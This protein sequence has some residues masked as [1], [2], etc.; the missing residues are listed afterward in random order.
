M[1]RRYGGRLAAD[2]QPPVVTPRPT[3][4]RPRACGVPRRVTSQNAPSSRSSGGSGSTGTS[5]RCRC[6]IYRTATPS[7]GVGPRRSRRPR[8]WRWRGR[9]WQSALYVRAPPPRPP[10]LA[11]PPRGAKSARWRRRRQRGEAARRGRAWQC[12]CDSG[13]RAGGAGWA[14]RG[15]CP[16]AI[17]WNTRGLGPPWGA[18]RADGVGGLRSDRV[19]GTIS[20]TGGRGGAGSDRCRAAAP[21]QPVAAPARDYHPEPHYTSAALGSARQR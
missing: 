12:V 15:G 6:L 5:D 16:A 7:R 19:T 14:S 20:C 3:P 18:R 2:P 1:P 11:R 17:Y 13:D 10:R 4:L 8:P 9:F 21:W